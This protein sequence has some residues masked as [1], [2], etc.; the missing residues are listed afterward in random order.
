MLDNRSNRAAPHN[1]V[2]RILC[3]GTGERWARRSRLAVILG[4][5]FPVSRCHDR[6]APA[7]QKDSLSRRLGSLAPLRFLALLDNP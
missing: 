6:N 2:R 1:H 4:P 5:D 7:K 3:S